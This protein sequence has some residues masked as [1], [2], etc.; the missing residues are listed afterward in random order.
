[1]ESWKILAI[2][3]PLLFV[4]YQTLSKYFPKDAPLL[5]ITALSSLVG[6]AVLFF[7]HMLSHEKV[8]LSNNSIIIAVAIGI[9][10]SVGNFFIMKAYAWGAPQSSFSTIFYPL[11]ILY[12]IIF[13]I[14]LWH[15]GLSVPQI[16]GIILIFGGLGLVMFYRT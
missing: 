8:V 9:L 1:M 7:I 6:A 13:G 5:F 10:V 12:S 16:A 2:F 4:T 15:E 14:F 11:F 3:T